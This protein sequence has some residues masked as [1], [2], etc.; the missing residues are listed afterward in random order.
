MYTIEYPGTYCTVLIILQKE[1]KMGNKAR[2]DNR[3]RCPRRRTCRKHRTSR[4]G[5]MNNNTGKNIYKKVARSLSDSL[6]RAKLRPAPSYCAR[7]RLHSFNERRRRIYFFEKVNPRT[8]SLYNS[9]L[10]SA[11]L[12]DLKSASSLRC[13]NPS[14]IF[15]K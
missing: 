2:N 12:S 11:C 13:P 9:P 7:A 6:N 3:R 15:S 14:S 4:R 10:E 8:D 1:T 5:G